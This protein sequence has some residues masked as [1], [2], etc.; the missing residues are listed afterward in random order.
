MGL[1]D[2]LESDT[3]IDLVVQGGGMRGIYS[4]GA[5]HTLDKLGYK[6]RF[7]N[8]WATS[9]GAINSAYFAAGQIEQNFDVYV[10]YLANRRFINPLRTKKNN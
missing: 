5:L 4:A 10:R 9:S 7:Q 3:P 6:D 8:I 1:T 2:I